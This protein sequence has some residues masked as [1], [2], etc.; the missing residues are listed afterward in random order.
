MPTPLRAGE[1]LASTACTTRVVVV[2]APSDG[3]VELEC[4]GS[5]MVA[6]TG[7]RPTGGPVKDAVT[8][9][10]KRYVNEDQSLEVLC[11]VPGIGSLSCDGVAMTIK[12][13]KA[14]PASD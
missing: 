7:S 5:P 1:Q 13:A 14:L 4:G 6:A 12:A 9:L 10:G 3:A 11:T 8:M 2:R